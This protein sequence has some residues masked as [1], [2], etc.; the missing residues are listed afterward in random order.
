MIDEAERRQL[1]HSRSETLGE[2]EA[3]TLMTMLPAKPL[4]ELA[5]REDMAGLRA[6]IQVEFGAIVA[7]GL[8]V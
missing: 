6:E 7:T 3:D 4:P 1:W 5:T 2:S 8:S